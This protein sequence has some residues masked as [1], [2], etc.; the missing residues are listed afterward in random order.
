MALEIVEI[1]AAGTFGHVAVVRDSSSA[2][3]HAAKVLRKEHLENAKLLHRMRDEAAMLERIDHPNVVRA[4]GVREIEGR[5]V[6]LLEWVRGAPIDALLARL[7][8]GLPPPEAVEIVRISTVALLAAYQ[9][10]DPLSGRAM[11][12]IH[13]D[14]K[15]SNVLLSIDG[16]VKVLDFGIAQ[17][18]F[19][20]KQSETITM[21]L[22]AH[23]YLA[24]ERLDGAPDAP[25]GDVYALGCSLFELLSGRRMKLSLNPEAHDDLMGRELIR[26]QPTDTNPRTLNELT[27]L[28]AAMC[29]YDP[30]RRPDHTEVVGALTRVLLGAGWQPNLAR[31]ARKHVVP[32]LEEQSFASPAEHPAYPE[33][34]FLEAPT[35]ETPIHAPPRESDE[36]L[37]AFL[38]G[39][40]WHHHREHLR[41]ILASDPSW[42]AAPFVEAI[43]RLVGGRFWRRFRDDDEAREQLLIALELLQARP[44]AEV[45]SRAKLLRGHPD[46]DVAILAR[47]ICS[48]RRR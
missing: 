14:F 17:G 27:E 29:A 40:D 11:Q 42:T 44:G 43:D 1:L 41:R 30:A 24:P 2:V 22:G 26:L 13:R 48:G 12:V 18:H 39:E 16:V 46:P 33:L 19:A 9:A 34:A 45:T 38:A 10:A 36:A 5:P 3:L 47:H 23:G 6:V 7:P 28:V 35:G 37:R 4:L 15:P 21:V 8:D 25:S 20:G 32:Y 31:L